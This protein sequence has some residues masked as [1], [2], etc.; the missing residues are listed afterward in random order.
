MP[1]IVDEYTQERLAIDVARK[2]TSDDV[3]ERL[4]D[5]F[6]CRGVPNHNRSD[7]GSKFNAKRAEWLE[8]VVVKTLYIERWRKAYN[9]V[10]PHSSLAYRPRRRAIVW[11]HELSVGKPHRRSVPAT[12]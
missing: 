3:L 9:T 1:T 10:R 7:N 5:F 12:C 6:V 4:S 11:R 2:L 8:R